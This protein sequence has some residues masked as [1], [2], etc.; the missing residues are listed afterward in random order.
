MCV[1][2]SNMVSA[3]FPTQGGDAATILILSAPMYS[4]VSLSLMSMSKSLDPLPQSKKNIK[5]KLWR[6]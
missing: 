3:E 5:L 4:N 1:S 2:Y 6:L